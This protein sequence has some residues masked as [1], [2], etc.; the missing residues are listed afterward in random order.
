MT[1]DGIEVAE[2]LRRR[3]GKSKLIVLGHSWGSILGIHM[4]KQ[5]PELFAAYVGTGQ[6]VR[7]SEDAKA[8]YPLLLE[9]AHATGNTEAEQQLRAVGPPPY[10][11]SPRKWVWV[12][13]ANR[14]DP[15]PAVAPRPRANAGRPP[16]YLE[17]GAEFSQGLMWESILRDD[18]R[19]LGLKFELPVVFIQGAED[20]LTVTAL[21]KQYFDSI[22]A[23]SKQ[24][25]V[26]PK[27][28][29]LAIFTDPDAFLNALTQYAR[30]LALT[31]AQ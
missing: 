17:D 24:F 29:H 27:V 7:L 6:V 22:S 20:R 21:A 8:A 1:Q 30:P 9:H 14:L 3:L 18:L 13:W 10:D 23:P 11:D 15:R 5:R 12:S 4:V 31:P 25:V 19:A 2:Y 28:G 26:L 16:A